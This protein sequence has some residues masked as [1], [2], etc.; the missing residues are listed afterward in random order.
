MKVTRADVGD[1]VDAAL[2][3][4]VRRDHFIDQNR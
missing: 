2:M 4:E 1:G 3:P